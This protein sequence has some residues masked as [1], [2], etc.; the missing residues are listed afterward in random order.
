MIKKINRKILVLLASAV[1]VLI[2]FLVYFSV[3]SSPSP[4]IFKVKTFRISGGWGYTITRDDAEF[5]Y[6]PFIPGISGKKAFPDKKHA[7]RAGKIVKEKLL[8]HEIPYF[9]REDL[10]KIGLD[11]LGNK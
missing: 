5:I 8:N 9:T 11:S 7:A 6:Q 3:Q 4:D 2:V 10:S 1:V